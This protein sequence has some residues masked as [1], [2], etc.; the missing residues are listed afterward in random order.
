MARQAIMTEHMFYHEHVFGVNTQLRRISAA[1]STIR[2]RR[3]T[4]FTT[5]SCE[6]NLMSFSSPGGPYVLASSASCADGNARATRTHAFAA[7]V[8][9]PPSFSTIRP[10]QYAL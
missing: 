5:S 10:A 3:G 4:T 9:S 6:Q 8:T 1:E 2:L 7:S